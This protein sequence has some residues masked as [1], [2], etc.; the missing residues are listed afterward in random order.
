MKTI[1]IHCAT[2]RRA[3]LVLVFFL[4]GLN[5]LA[6][7][8]PGARIYPTRSRAATNSAGAMSP[9][10]TTPPLPDATLLPPSGASPVAASETPKEIPGYTFNYEG[11]D[12]SQVLD[13]YADLVNKTLIHGN[14]PAASI[15]LKT[16]TPL[17]KTEAIH[18]LEAVLALNNISV[19]PMND[20]FVK[21]VTTDQAGSS[22]APFDL[23][24]AENLPDVGSYVTHIVQLQYVKPSVMQGIL[25]PLGKVNNII[26][27]DD[28]G[29]LVIR[30]YAENVKRMLE[31]ISQIDIS[32]P[33]EYTNEVI[34]IKYALATDIEE[35]LNSLG[36]QGGASTVAIGTSAGST[37]INGFGSPQRTTGGTLGSATT[38][39]TI[40]GGGATGYAGGQ[41][42]AFGAQA[43]T[44]NGTATGGTTFQSRLSALLNAQGSRPGGGGG[45][46][47]GQQDQ[48]QVF[49][50]AKIIADARANSLLVFATR[51][52]MERI[53]AVVAK[54]DVL[55]SQV[56]IESVIMDVNLGKA[57]SYGVSAAQQQKTINGNNPKIITGGGF[58]NGNPFFNFLNS[59]TNDITAILP[60]PT[61]I[62][63]V[64]AG[65]L[66]YFGN[67]GPTWDVA[68]E[69]AAG[70]SAI[71]I[72]QRPR[73]QASQAKPA[74]F[75]VGNTVPY[76]TGTTIG[77]GIGNG[78]S[79]TY[80]TLN[81]GIELDVTPFIN[82]DGLVVMDINQ[83]ID[84]I[85]D[86]TTIDGNPVPIT[87]K[88]TLSSEIAVRDKDT[89][90]LGG[91]I[92]SDQRKTKQGI[93]LLQDIPL[94]GAL[95]SKNDSSKKREE[96]IVLMRPTV[97]QTPA[98]A[99]QHTLE[100]EQQLP[101]ISAASAEYDKQE[102]KQIEAE[103]KE[104][105]KR[106][107]LRNQNNGYFTPVPPP[108]ATDTNIALPLP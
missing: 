101:A 108:A 26:P 95:F 73:I 21:V 79:S 3:A 7:L 30:D 1:R 16:K 94:L 72:I 55:L 76:I 14:I 91:F 93:P 61:T 58:N 85:S 86:E 71:N 87:D 9:L 106:A 23:T 32:S 38:T 51:A 56:L 78:Q 70:D 104:E 43:T 82:P 99:A 49:G 83:E 18:A 35:A 90:M 80:S 98:I 27:I 102:A 36:G 97:L 105:E 92:R 53:K 11:V 34:P 5:L 17:T 45:G 107:R 19:I 42:A 77:T 39:P 31:M 41:R 62:N 67:I 22:G 96:L 29:I 33:Q 65:Q 100:E 84:D 50:Q 60:G 20:K 69:A 103:R 59:V 46:A 24:T 47:N 4:T 28:N 57:L 63:G 2:A 25:T 13:T 66:S 12:V 15:V 8:P 81:V 74:T 44:A 75:F 89:L 37:T 68:I 52:D 48:I 40:S 88:R 54:L 10:P 6:Q 64:G